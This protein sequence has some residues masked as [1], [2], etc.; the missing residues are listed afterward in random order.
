MKH[1]EGAAEFTGTSVNLFRCT[2]VRVGFH[3]RR[4]SRLLGWA[5]WPDPHSLITHNCPLQK[6]CNV[7]VFKNSISN[8]SFGTTTTLDLASDAC[9][10]SWAEYTAQFIYCPI[11]WSR[12]IVS[13]AMLTTNKAFRFFFQ[14]RRWKRI[15][16]RQS[17]SWNRRCADTCVWAR[18][19]S[20]YA[21][22]RRWTAS[23]SA[24]PAD[25]PFATWLPSRRQA[26]S[27]TV[28]RRMRHCWQEM[29]FRKHKMNVHFQSVN[30]FVHCKRCKDVV[31]RNQWVWLKSR[32]SGLL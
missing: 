14:M 11:H 8:S 25:R 32:D 2:P 9:A 15:S 31:G 26:E 18:T 21:S 27:L 16:G 22:T 24:T 20:R 1:L 3:C 13:L 23:R 28:Q 10:W 6:Y 7:V 29:I 17:K 4:L 19:S 12:P 30:H 5:G